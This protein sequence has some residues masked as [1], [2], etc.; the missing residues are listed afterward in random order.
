MLLGRNG[1]VGSAAGSQGVA[2]YVDGNV[3]HFG[4][5]VSN[6]PLFG[7]ALARH[8]CKRRLKPHTTAWSTA[9]LAFT[10]VQTIHLKTGKLYNRRMTPCGAGC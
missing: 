6:E 8:P 4:A 3:E 7:V 1:D 9:H 5:G 2:G 10:Q